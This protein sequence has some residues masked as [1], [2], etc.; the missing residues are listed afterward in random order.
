MNGRYA[1]LN[2]RNKKIADEFIDFL[3]FRQTQH[4]KELME[5]IRD[6]EEGR[7]EGP[8]DSLEALTDALNQ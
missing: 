2:P 5:A 6:C 3:Y 1:E 7:T 4:E 8:Y